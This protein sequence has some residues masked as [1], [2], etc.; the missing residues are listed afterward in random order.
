[1]P[2]IYFVN[3]KHRQNFEKLQ[4]KFPNAKR[5][6]DYRAACYIAAHPEIIKC[7][8]V[9]RQKNGPFDWYF[10]YLEDP[11]DFIRRRDRG[12]TTGDTAPL[13]GQT[14]KLL[15][16][17]L[18]LWNGRSCDISFMMDL[19]KDLY[20][21]ALQGIDLLRRRPTID[22]AYMADELLDLEPY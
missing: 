6:G 19:D 7:F 10:D 14:R 11:E 2:D 18:G 17:G 1:M 16:L 4:V 8:N 20:L 5:A 9:F 15:E 22:Y 3:D 13:T 21:V 12:E